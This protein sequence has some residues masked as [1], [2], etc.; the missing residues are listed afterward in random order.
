MVTVG[1][2]YS[3][4][5]NR[6]CIGRKPTKTRVKEKSYSDSSPIELAA[7]NISTNPNGYILG[8]ITK[9]G[10]IIDAMNV[11][12]QQEIGVVNDKYEEAKV[13]E[14]SKDDVKSSSEKIDLKK[15]FERN[16][17]LAVN[18]GLA[19]GVLGFVYA[20]K[21]GQGKLIPTTI[22]LIVGGLVGNQL[23]KIKKK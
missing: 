23:G 17:K 4:R 10:Y 18:L 20:L 19:G 22:G 16:T 14:T 2:V 7:A 21:N 12:P 1:K 6:P 11:F 8:F 3:C 13:Q 15:G 9:D 5:L